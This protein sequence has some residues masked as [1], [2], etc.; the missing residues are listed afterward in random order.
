[1]R[2][3]KSIQNQAIKD[4]AK[5]KEKKYRDMTS[6]FIIEGEHLVR[7]AMEAGNL[8]TIL[9]DEDSLEKYLELVNEE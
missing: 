4:I 7:M 2:I 8:E 9:V 5:L 6:L 3:I 1:M